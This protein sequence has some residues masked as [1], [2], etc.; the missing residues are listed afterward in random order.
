MTHGTL[1]TAPFDAAEVLDT[2]E[3]VEELVAAAFETEGPAFQLARRRDPLH[4]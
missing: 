3:A 1:K 2:E 4:L